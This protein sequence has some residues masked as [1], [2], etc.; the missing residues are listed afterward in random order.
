MP[1]VMFNFAQFLVAESRKND[2][3]FADEETEAASLIWQYPIF[4][5]SPEFVQKYIAD[6]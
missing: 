5:T 2:H 1:R 6:F 4:Y 3:A